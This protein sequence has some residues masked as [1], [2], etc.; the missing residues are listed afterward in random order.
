MGMDL[1]L[2]SISMGCGLGLHWPAA[3]HVKSRFI[4]LTVKELGGAVGTAVG[5][6]VGPAVGSVV[7]SAVG[8]VVGTAVG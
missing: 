3:L 5:S 7:G 4:W 2:L 8:L 1:L 6:V